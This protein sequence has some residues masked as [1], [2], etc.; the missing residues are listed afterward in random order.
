[1]EA[2][3]LYGENYSKAQLPWGGSNAWMSIYMIAISQ[4]TLRIIIPQLHVM[5]SDDDPTC[6]N[7]PKPPFCV[8]A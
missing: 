3:N 5:G 4:K 7:Q 8:P 1:V 2:N 6:C